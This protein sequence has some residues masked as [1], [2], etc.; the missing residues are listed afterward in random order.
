MTLDEGL[1]ARHR[2]GASWLANRAIYNDTR[3][4]DTSG[5]ATLSTQLSS[6]VPATLLATRREEGSD[7]G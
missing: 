5:N 7:V 4:F 3:Q 1:P 2:Q 6:D